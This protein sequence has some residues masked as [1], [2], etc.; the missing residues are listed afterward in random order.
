MFKLIYTQEL[1][2]RMLSEKNLLLLDVRQEYEHQE[3][4]LPGSILIPLD[5][6][7]ERVD[8]LDEYRE[9]E[10]IVYCK[11]GVRSAYACQI[12]LAHQ[13]TNLYNLADGI[14]AW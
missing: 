1:K 9:Q 4:C 5:Q 12:L 14:L 6:L 3:F 2:R 11:A 7:A 13:F 8:E 10:L